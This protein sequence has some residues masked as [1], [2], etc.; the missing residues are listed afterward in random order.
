MKEELNASKVFSS[1]AV[2]DMLRDQL[3]MVFQSITQT[4]TGKVSIDRVADFLR[5]VCPRSTLVLG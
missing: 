5:K 3:H 1:M 2:F 4:M